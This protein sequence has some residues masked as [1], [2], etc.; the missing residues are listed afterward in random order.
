MRLIIIHGSGLV[1]ILDKIASYKKTFNP[2]EILTISAKTHS[3]SEALLEIRAPG[4]FDQKKLI[5][6]EDFDENIPL[7]K[8][9]TF[10]DA[11]IIVKFLKSL[12]ANS[13]VI[14]SAKLLKATIVNLEEEKETTIFPFL[15]AVSEKNH[16]ALRL[17]TNLINEYGCLY[18]ITM[19][20]FMFRRL[21]LPPKKATFFYSGKIEIW[22]KNFPFEGLGSFYKDLIQSEFKIKQGLQEDKVV[23]FNLVIKLLD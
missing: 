11:T 18:V 13:K 1:A 10:L 6:L 14:N 8:L 23:L 5:I 12:S 3:A 20:G 15:D 17:L 16:K 19:L 9:P 22:K 21:V 2:L 4:L 7:D